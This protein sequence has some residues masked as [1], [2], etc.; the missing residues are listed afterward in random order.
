MARRLND[1]LA[2]VFVPSSEEL[3]WIKRTGNMSE[4]QLRDQINSYYSSQ[5]WYSR[6]ALYMGLKSPPA[7]IRGMKANLSVKLKS[8]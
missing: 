3:G 6:I 1:Y 8:E 5:P 2:R 7:K 4:E